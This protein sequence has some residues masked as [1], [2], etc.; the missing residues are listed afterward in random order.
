MIA[1]IFYTALYTRRA[2]SERSPFDKNYPRRGASFSSR[3]SKVCTWH[4]ITPKS[5]PR[6]RCCATCAHEHPRRCRSSDRARLEM[7]ALWRDSRL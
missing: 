4:C 1:A 2:F 5:H 3:E 6:R 7:V